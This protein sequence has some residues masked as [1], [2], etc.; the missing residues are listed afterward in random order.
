MNSIVLGSEKNQLLLNIL[1]GVNNNYFKPNEDLMNFKILSNTNSLF[2]LSNSIF[3]FSYYTHSKYLNALR[4]SVTYISNT[5]RFIY[6]YN[7]TFSVYDIFNSTTCFETTNYINCLYFTSHL[8]SYKFQVA[9]IDINSEDLLCYGT[10]IID[11]S[12]ESYDSNIF[13]KGIH[14]E[15]EICAYIFFQILEQN[16][17]L[18]F[19]ILFVKKVP[20]TLICLILLI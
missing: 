14:L 15:D 2:R 16:Q 13:R 12:S 3:L 17:S 9:I 8:L 19:K 7:N 18:Q 20:K 11:T 10:C 1:Y 6:K 5:F 4:F